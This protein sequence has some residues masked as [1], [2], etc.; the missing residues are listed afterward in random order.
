MFHSHP[1]GSSGKNHFRRCSWTLSMNWLWT[2]LQMPTDALYVIHVFLPFFGLRHRDGP[3]EGYASALAE[4]GRR[5]F[6]GNCLRCI[7]RVLFSVTSNPFWKGAGHTSI[8]EKLSDPQCCLNGL[9]K[10][11]VLFYPIWAQS[12]LI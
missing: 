10:R 6:K 5:S 11:T 9:E 8:Y 12:F 4:Q 1:R 2:R 3:K 7:Q